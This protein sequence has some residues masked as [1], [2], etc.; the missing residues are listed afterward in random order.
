MLCGAVLFQA[1]EIQC[2]DVVVSAA[3]SARSPG[4]RELALGARS[5]N[6]PAGYKA[7]THVAFQL[8]RKDV[9]KHA[10]KKI[11]KY[12]KCHSKGAHIR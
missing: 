10:Y 6:A 7:S 12:S 11:L 2:I 8:F 4:S 3:P 1:Y 5:A 9:S